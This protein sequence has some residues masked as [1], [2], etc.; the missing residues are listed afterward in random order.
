MQRGITTGWALALL[1]VLVALIALF[2]ALFRQTGEVPQQGANATSTEQQAASVPYESSIYGFSLRHPHGFAV[3]ERY[4]YQ[5]LGPGRDIPGVS[6]TVP[7]SFSH[8][9]NLSSD[10][11]LSVERL[12]AA[13]STCD[14]ALFLESPSA[15][16]TAVT[17]AGV[18]YST[19]AQSG[20]GAGNRYEET[21]YALSDSSPCTAVRYFIHSTAIENYPEGAVRQYDKAALVAVF[22]S[23][24]RSLTLS[25]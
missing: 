20:A 23:I 18:R 7:A 12:S 19:L 6:F 16:S 13:T 4:S 17:E 14:A 9:T 24:R 25:R 15:S 1:I 22:D 8:G 3:D 5:G 2:Y 11:R 10:S 21:I